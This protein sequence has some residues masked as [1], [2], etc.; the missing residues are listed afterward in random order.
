MTL[1]QKSNL[2]VGQVS[3]W[4]LCSNYLTSKARSVSSTCPNDEPHWLVQNASTNDISC[5]LRR[6]ISCKL[7]MD[8]RSLNSTIIAFS[9]DVCL[10]QF[11]CR[12]KDLDEL[13]VMR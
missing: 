3:H 10:K 13:Y 8:H 2:A 12:W 7:D 9:C 11:K 4:R 6:K 1:V 5:D